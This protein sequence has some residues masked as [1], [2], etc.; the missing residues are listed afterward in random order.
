VH[1]WV[2]VGPGPARILFTFVPG[3]IDDFF[4]LIGQTSAAEWL[5]LGQR[6]DIWTVGESMVADQQGVAPAEEPVP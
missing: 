5:A 3:G 2:N 1:G 4:R 6:H